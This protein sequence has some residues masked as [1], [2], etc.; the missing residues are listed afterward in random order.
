ME[1]FFFFDHFAPIG[2]LELKLLTE[3]VYCT[4]HPREEGLTR[5]ANCSCDPPPNPL[6]SNL[7]AL[8]YTYTCALTPTPFERSTLVLVVVRSCNPN[9]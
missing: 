9:P 7:R 8:T 3:V 5:L 1:N 6:L 4:P 2:W